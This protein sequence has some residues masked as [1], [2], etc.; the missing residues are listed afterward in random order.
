MLIPTKLNYKGALYVKA[1]V[2]DEILQ[3]LGGPRR[4]KAMIGAKNFLSEKK[5]LGA[6]RFDFMPGMGKKGKVNF[7][8]ITLD[9]SDTYSVEFGFKTKS[10]YKKV[11]EFDNIYVEQLRKLF[12][13]ETGLRLSL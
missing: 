8:R 3:Q 7:V 13:S 4:L 2:A 6:L 11:S 5:G 1:N 9:P 12:E 10:G